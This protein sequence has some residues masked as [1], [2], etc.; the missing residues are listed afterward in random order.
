MDKHEHYHSRF[1]TKCTVWNFKMNCIIDNGSTT[2]LISI[3]QYNTIITNSMPSLQYVSYSLLD[4]KEKPF[5]VYGKAEFEFYFENGQKYNSP[6][7]VC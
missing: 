3:H 4:V 5:N 2:S 7:I 6:A 1:Y